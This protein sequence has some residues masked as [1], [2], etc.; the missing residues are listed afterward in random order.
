MSVCVHIHRIPW[1][2]WVSAATSLRQAWVQDDLSIVRPLLSD[3]DASELRIVPYTPGWFGRLLGNKPGTLWEPSIEAV[4]L[5]VVSE[6]AVGTSWVYLADG[7]ALATQLQSVGFSKAGEILFQ[8]F[9]KGYDLRDEDPVHPG[10]EGL[11]L[12][13]PADCS[14]VADAL[15]SSEIDSQADTVVAFRSAFVDRAPG[16]G[17]AVI[18]DC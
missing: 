7:E 3:E 13:A 1:H 11:M 16:Q 6:V 17:V 9:G 2:G 4:T 5:A 15:A 8:A 12:L 18:T 14:V 10:M